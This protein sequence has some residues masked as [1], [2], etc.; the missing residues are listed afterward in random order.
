MFR[1]GSHLAFFTSDAHLQFL[2]RYFHIRSKHV[3]LVFGTC[4]SIFCLVLSLFTLLLAFLV[5][6]QPM[7]MCQ[8]CCAGALVHHPPHLCR[9]LELQLPLSSAAAAV[10]VLPQRLSGHAEGAGLHHLCGEG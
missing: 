6:K 8:A 4:W 9:L 1:I 5:P 2:L 3:T 10:S 7:R